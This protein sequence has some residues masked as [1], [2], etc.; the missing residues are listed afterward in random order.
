MAILQRL[1]RLTLKDAWVTVAPTLK[2]IQ[3]LLNNL[4]VVID[5]AYH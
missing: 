3:G 2:V 1:N 4:K 5:G